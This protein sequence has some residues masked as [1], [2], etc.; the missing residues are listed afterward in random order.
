MG[1]D[2][3]AGWI[4]YMRGRLLFVKYYPYFPNGA[5]PPN[6]LLVVSRLV[7]PELLFEI[8]AMAVKPAAAAAAKRPVARSRAT[9]KQAARRK[10]SRKRG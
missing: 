7:Q 6:T 4:A 3:D 8:E 5:Y 9:R 2:S 10:T 1:A